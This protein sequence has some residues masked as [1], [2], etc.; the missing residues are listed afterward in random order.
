LKRTHPNGINN[1]KK[2]IKNMFCEK[3]GNI[4]VV[5]SFIGDKI[6]HVCNLCKHETIKDEQNEKIL[7]TEIANA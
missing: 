3:C 2:E 1:I 5:K 6:V 4:M 7:L